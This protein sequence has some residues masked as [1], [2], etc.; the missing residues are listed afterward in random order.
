MILVCFSYAQTIPTQEEILT[1][2]NEGPGWKVYKIRNQLLS[3]R[4]KVD[5]CS[6]DY[7]LINYFLLPIYAKLVDTV[8]LKATAEELYSYIKSDGRQR[9]RD[10]GYNDD[11]VNVFSM[12]SSQAL[13]NCY[14]NEQN[15]AQA[16]IIAYD[17][18]NYAKELSGHRNYFRL[19]NI[20]EDAEETIAL[21]SNEAIGLLW[22]YHE[23]DTLFEGLCEKPLE[24]DLVNE[25]AEE[26]GFVS[27]YD[28]F[29]Y[30]GESEELDKYLDAWGI[31]LTKIFEEEITEDNL[32]EWL[33]YFDDSDNWEYDIEE[34]FEDNRNDN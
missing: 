17:C 10:Y 6:T 18:L 27:D 2:I 33:N 12:I 14:S 9:L 32:E 29:G 19:Q 25:K 11:D 15:Y 1:V 22:G 31:I 28:N 26:K 4:A 3:E 5:S 8:T 24:E 13:M 7:Q 16:E 23:M 30:G 34:W 21:T 20:T